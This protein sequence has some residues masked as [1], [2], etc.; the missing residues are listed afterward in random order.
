MTMCTGYFNKLITTMYSE[1][2]VAASSG[3]TMRDGQVWKEK[4]T[5]NECDDQ[6]T[7]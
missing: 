2:T 3:I 4:N 7:I 5:S 6:W 1:G